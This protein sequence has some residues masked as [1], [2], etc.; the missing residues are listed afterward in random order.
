[1]MGWYFVD[2]PSLKGQTLMDKMIGMKIQR[3]I[4]YTTSEQK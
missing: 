4:T 3:N 1:M 2:I